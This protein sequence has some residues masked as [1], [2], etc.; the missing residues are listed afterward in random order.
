[1]RNLRTHFP[2]KSFI[3]TYLEPKMRKNREKKDF[4]VTTQPYRAVC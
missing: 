2:V 3:S 1:M 4:N